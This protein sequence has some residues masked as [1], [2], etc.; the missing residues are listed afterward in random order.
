MPA[1]LPQTSRLQKAG[2][3][4][5]LGL[6]LMAVLL[7]LFSFTAAGAL[8]RDEIGLVNISLLP[9]WKEILDGLMHDHCP[10]V[11][12]AV[13]R[14][15]SALGLAHTDTGW[16]VLGLC[17]G[18]LLP[19]SFWAASRMMGKSLPLLSLALVAVNPVVIRYGDSMRGYAMGMVLIVLTMGLVWRFIEVP[20]VWR[21]L[22]AGLAAVVSVQT[23]Y[24]NA[25][26][27]LAI[28]VGGIVVSLRQ[29]QLAKAFGILGIGFVAALS[30][31]PYVGP[32]RQAQSWW[33][34]SQYGINLDMARHHLANLTG[35]FLNVWVLVVVIA[36]ITGLGRVLL[37]PRQSPGS[38]QQDLPLFGS[39][40]LVLGTIG[41]AV[42]I[43]SSGLPTQ[44]WYYIP[45]LCFTVLC[46]DAV[47]PRV[48]PV[49]ALGVLVIAIGALVISPSACSALRWRQTNCDLLAA[50]ISKE[51]KAGDLII[52]HPWFNGLSFAHNYRGT[53]S[54]TTLPPIGDYRF[55]RYDLIKSEEQKTNAIAP[56][57]KQAEITLR[58]GKRV[59]IVGGI[60]WP[61]ADAKAPVPLPPAPNGR[62]GWLDQPYTVAWGK[63]LGY[64]LA[65]H[66]TNVARLVDQGTNAIPI[67]PLENMHL[68]SVSGWTTDN[69]E[70]NRP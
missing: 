31:V 65:H 15:W 45:V 60:P 16:R 13:M 63:E 58:S 19:A 3:I 62:Y 17:V 22:L 24:Q 57:L 67:S 47:L 36:A 52:V 53:T 27:L 28:G 39:I 14:T 11:F 42:F 7:H 1:T 56:V 29:R 5:A 20:N 2:W 4:A 48:L 68:T 18:L 35:F 12:P 49:T 6:T 8:W 23:L 50:Q 32:I 70:T 43:K 38:D 41:F 25:F 55:Y 21:G 54:W 59:W 46:C 69:S 33:V 37:T 44:D 61:P 66:T 26:F 51:A 34:V 64:F 10:V 9:S 40:A 30:L